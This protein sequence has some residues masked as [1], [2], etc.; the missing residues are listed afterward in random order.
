MKQL[1]MICMKLRP[2]VCLECISD[3]MT[4]L[5]MEFMG[6]NSTVILYGLLSD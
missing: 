2:S 5:M 3:S 1:G 4:G 6:F